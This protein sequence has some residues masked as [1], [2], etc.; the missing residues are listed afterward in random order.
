MP[1]LF[2]GAK[3]STDHHA[4]IITLSSSMALIGKI[5]REIGF[6]HISLSHELMPMI[7]LVSRATSVCADAYLTPAIRKYIDGFSAGFEGGLGTRSVQQQSG[8]KGARC[9]FMQS[10]GGLVDVEKFTGLKA[11]LS[12]PAGGVVGYAITSYDE[13]TKTPVIGFDM[14]CTF[15]GWV[16][17]PVK[18]SRNDVEQHLTCI[19]RN[20]YGCVTVW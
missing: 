18:A 20:E 5:A 2:A 6:E 7:K 9:E 4:R 14:V 16:T 17:A 11:I 8:S 10:D 3:S 15:R 12:G 13:E 19:G 1:A